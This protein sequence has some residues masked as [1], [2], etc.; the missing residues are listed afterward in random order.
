MSLISFNLPTPTQH[1][2][3]TLVVSNPARSGDKVKDLTKV[4][5]SEVDKNKL[6]PVDP[7]PGTSVN[8]VNKHVWD[9]IHDESLE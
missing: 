3:Y 5:Y 1:H 7:P 9:S 4:V 6:K 2:Q 8:P